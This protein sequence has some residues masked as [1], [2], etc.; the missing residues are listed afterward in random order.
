MTVIINMFQPTLGADELEA[1]GRVFESNWIGKGKIT[2]QFED[3]FA[4]YVGVDRTLIRSVSCCTEGLFQSM[5][6]LGNDLRQ[7]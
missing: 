2:Q 7:Q 1:V 4:D 6:L 5:T 3:R